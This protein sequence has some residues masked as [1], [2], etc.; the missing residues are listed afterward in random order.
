MI[1]LRSGGFVLPLVRPEG[2]ELP[3]VNNLFRSLEA[4]PRHCYE[5]NQAA[6]FAAPADVIGR[7][8]DRVIGPRR[9]R[10]RQN[11]ER[12]R[13]RARWRVFSLFFFLHLFFCLFFEKDSR[14]YFLALAVA[15]FCIGVSLA[16]EGVMDSIGFCF[17]G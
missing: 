2:R 6:K 12:P 4:H 5:G 17:V 7:S 11:R 9:V 10:A 3:P 16:C 8:S 13:C 14:A 15:F 1:F